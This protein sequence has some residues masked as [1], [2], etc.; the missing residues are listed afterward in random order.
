MC[1][2]C[3]Q[4]PRPWFHL[5]HPLDARRTL[6]THWTLV[7]YK[8]GQLESSWE[9]ARVRSQCEPSA[10][11]VSGRLERAWFTWFFCVAIAHESSIPALVVRISMQAPLCGLTGSG[12][13]LS[14]GTCRGGTTASKAFSRH[15]PGEPR[16]PNVLENKDA[17]PLCG[18][19]YILHHPRTTDCC[20]HAKWGEWVI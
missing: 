11:S 8:G 16:H 15:H 5:L 1:S 3:K 18:Q 4:S 9:K 17:K 7:Y 19:A 6:S 20:L 2:Q 12:V 14:S 13:E 10:C